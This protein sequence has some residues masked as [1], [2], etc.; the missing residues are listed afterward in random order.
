M[1]EPRR[2]AAIARAMEDAHGRPVLDRL[3]V[4]CVEL[5]GVTGAGIVMVSDGQQRGS[6]AVSDPQ[7]GRIDDLQFSLGEG[8]CIDA[9]TS[10]RPVLEPDLSRGSAA[11]HWPAF[12][13]A[14]L[15]DGTSAA[16]AFPL[17]L[18]AARFGALSLYRD[19]PGELADEGFND[20]LFVARI[21]T[22]VLMELQAGSRPG[23]VSGQMDEV[24]DH[25]AQVHQATG[26]VAAQLGS[27]VATALLRLRAAAWAE[28]VP[29][30]H[31]AA[32]VVARQRRFEEP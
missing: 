25:R 30:E 22:N 26:M 28:G 5:L 31:V 6:M 17:V 21:A 32:D 8:P 13:P 2:F 18:G 9:T 19:K 24:M 27:D 4:A 20:A 3:L 14:A 29:L 7:V 15:E 16:F 12:A 11:G 1:V 10:S 23:S